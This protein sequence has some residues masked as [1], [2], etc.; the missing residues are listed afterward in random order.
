MDSHG[1]ALLAYLDGDASAYEIIRRD[2]GLETPLPVS[3][4]FRMPEDFS[5]IER[6]ALDAC[7][8]HILD[9]G[10]GSGM[11]SLEL[12][13]RGQRV[14]SLD[15]SPAAVEVMRRR[16]LK[17]VV[18]ADIFEYSGGPFDTLLLLGNGIGMVETMAGL[19]RF[20]PCAASLL[21]EGGHVLFDSLD[22]TATDD[23]VH[24]AYHE[25]NR[26]AGREIGSTR[27]RVEFG[28]MIG[29][30]FG[31]LH[32]APDVLGQAVSGHGWTADI[33]AEQQG[34][35]YLARLSRVEHA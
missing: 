13:R 21:R 10:A 23:P 17:D 6:A 7:V 4:Y 20:L 33:V 34:G 18:C 29:P 24:L 31:W 14:T 26:S 2:D 3:H 25:L 12:V 28:G 11:H 30:Y 5:G 19:G 27:I 32:A 8:G 9:V 16:G 35:G 22:V 15:V 1:A